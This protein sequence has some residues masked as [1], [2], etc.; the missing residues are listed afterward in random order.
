M[1]KIGIPKYSCTFVSVFCSRKWIVFT[2]IAEAFFVVS[3]VMALSSNKVGFPVA[4]SSMF[5]SLMIYMYMEK[6]IIKA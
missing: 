3:V 2:I 5:L 6:Y 1:G 4:D